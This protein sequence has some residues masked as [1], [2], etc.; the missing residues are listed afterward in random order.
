[1]L[2]KKISMS[3]FVEIDL[4]SDEKHDNNKVKTDKN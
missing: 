2:E 3:K 1:M 4:S